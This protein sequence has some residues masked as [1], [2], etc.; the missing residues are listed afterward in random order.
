[1][2][3]QKPL[4]QLDI[5]QAGRQAG[6][7]YHCGFCGRNGSRIEEQKIVIHRLPDGRWEDSMN[8]GRVGGQVVRYV[9]YGCGLD[10][11]RWP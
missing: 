2:A 4:T 6:G 10:L 11:A 1:M 7:K 3:D 8:W 9:C 5:I